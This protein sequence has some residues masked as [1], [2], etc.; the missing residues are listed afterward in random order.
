MINTSNGKKNGHKKNGTAPDSENKNTDRPAISSS[1][2]V[3]PRAVENRKV[4]K[5]AEPRNVRMADP[6]L[7]ES[8]MTEIDLSGPTSQGIL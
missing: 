4:L 1:P 7:D 2:E 8:K 6:K 3:S 5:P